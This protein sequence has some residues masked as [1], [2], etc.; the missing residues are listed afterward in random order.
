MIE[1]PARTTTP[2]LP[3]EEVTKP[4]FSEAIRLGSLTHPQI[5]GDWQEIPIKGTSAGACAVGVAMFSV[6][7]DLYAKGVAAPN[8][9]KAQRHMGQ[10]IRGLRGGRWTCPV[11]QVEGQAED[12]TSNRYGLVNTVMH[13]NDVHKWTFNQIADYLESVGR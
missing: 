8:I 12:C 5:Q 3:I 10:R 9:L 6:G 1:A 2:S 7:I 13:L 4:T 11:F